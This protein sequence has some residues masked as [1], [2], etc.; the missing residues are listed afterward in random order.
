M[1]KFLVIFLGI[2]ILFAGCTSNDGTIPPPNNDTNNSDNNSNN[3]NVSKTLYQQI[4]EEAICP[5]STFAPLKDCKMYFP[6]CQHAPIVESMINTMIAEG[7]SKAEILQVLDRYNNGIIEDKL[8]DFRN[9]QKEGRVILVYFKSS[10]CE[11]CHEKEPIF[12]QIKEKYQGTVD[13]YVF[14]R[15]EDSV[16]FDYFAV[17]RIPSIVFYDGNTRLNE[18]PYNNITVN[19]VSNILDFTLDKKK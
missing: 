6:D 11:T 13:I 12:N 16:I 7:K 8:K 3:G 19:D 15:I 5:C 14:D 2:L 9:S 1:K 4:Q 18:V 17:D 10:L